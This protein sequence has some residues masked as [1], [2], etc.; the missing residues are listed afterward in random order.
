[1]NYPFNARNGH[2]VVITRIWG[3][4]KSHNF[5]LALD[6]GSSDTMVNA[7]LLADIGY[8]LSLHPAV[9]MATVGGIIQAPEV[10]VS[11]LRALG[12]LRTDFPVLAHTLPPTATVDGVLG[13]DFLRGH[14]IN[15]DLLLG[16]LTFD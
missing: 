12:N 3:P 9:S 14:V 5:F 8:D 2:I 1:M 6:T 11:Q 10:A 15:I 4:L 16:R 7:E 13:L